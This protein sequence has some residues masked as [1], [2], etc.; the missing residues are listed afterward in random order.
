MAVARRMS[1]G[2][3]TEVDIWGA[4][5]QSGNARAV[6]LHNATIEGGR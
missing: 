2:R 1:R 3:V 6:T 4:R 5:D